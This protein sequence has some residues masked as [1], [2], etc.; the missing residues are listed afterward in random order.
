[1]RSIY[2]SRSLSLSLSLSLP[3]TPLPLPTPKLPKL[4]TTI[5]SRTARSR[6]STHPAAH[7]RRAKGN[8]LRYILGG[9]AD[10]ARARDSALALKR[11]LH[12][13]V[14]AIVHAVQRHVLGAGDGNSRRPVRTHAHAPTNARISQGPS[15]GAGAR[16]GAFRCLSCEPT[17]RV[18]CSASPS[19]RSGD[20]SW[21]ERRPNV[22]LGV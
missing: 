21:L 7:R 16:G 14:E 2:V 13:R 15:K 8:L 19:R 3:P 20:S 4:T 11:L 12:R 18:F 17:C 6:C 5:G 22:S 9:R 1:M 10:A